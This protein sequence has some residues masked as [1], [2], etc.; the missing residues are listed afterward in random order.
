MASTCTFVQLCDH[1][2]SDTQWYK[3]T[4]LLWYELNIPW[5]N[6]GNNIGFPNE[7]VNMN[8]LDTYYVLTHCIL[9]IL[10]ETKSEDHGKEANLLENGCYHCNRHLKIGHGCTERKVM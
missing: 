7:R 10:A 8:R 1:N 2:K 9:V 5:L 4:M 6:V 3:T